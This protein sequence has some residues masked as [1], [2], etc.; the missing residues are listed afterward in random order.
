[1]KSILTFL[2]LV[3]ACDAAFVAGD[4]PRQPNIVFILADDLAWSDLGCYG[5]PWHNTPHLDR[6]AEQGTKFT[7][8]YAAAPICSA[9]RASLLTGKTTARLG[10]EFVTKNEPGHQ[11]LDTETPLQAP[12]ITLNLPLEETT[13]PETLRQAG[14][15]TAFFGKWHLN[16]HHGRY[17]G[18]SP[19]HGPLQQGFE[20]ATED[21]GGHPYSW[22]KQTPDPITKHGQ[23]PDDSMIQRTT[24][25]LRRPHDR[26]FFAMVS[27]FYVHTPVK[28]PCR[29]LVEK[30]EQLIPEDSPR[31][32]SRLQYAAF[33]ET[34]DHYVGQILSA[35][36]E[37][38]MADDTL[39]V[40]TSDNG[41]HPEFTANGP[42]RG[43]K[44]NLYEGGIRVPMLV[45]WPGRVA[46]NADCD[47]SVIG[48]DLHATFASAVHASLATTD[49]QNLMPLLTEQEPLP[50]RPLIWHFPY[51]HPERGFAKAP[52]AIGIDDFVTSRTR[53][54]S[55]MRVGPYKLLK[56]YETE[57]VELYNLVD[58]PAEQQ[59]IF[60][61]QT[62]VASRLKRQLEQQLSLMNARMPAPSSR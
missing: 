24:E 3:F 31:R 21:F 7:S 16:A 53:P 58:D 20:I 44:W 32:P 38:G 22:G 50:E 55:A 15:E 60:D 40:F 9:S 23:F 28:T 14:Y 8:A 29:W 37:S 12:P 56:F 46:A 6:L 5:H 42:L 11:L 39:V 57:T 52:D 17:L 19:T 2:V 18:W 33:V 30:Y 1:M 51:Y 43:S 62:V 48:Y 41:G 34:L 61:Q 27:Q 47:E 59:N 54:H 36:D 45:R 13:I 26:P 4:D 10:F 25:Y 49:G 35:I